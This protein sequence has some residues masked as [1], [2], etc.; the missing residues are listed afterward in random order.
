[1]VD[2]QQL[3][4][5]QPSLWSKSS[6]DWGK[7]GHELGVAAG[8]LNDQTHRPIVSGGWSG[9]AASTA[10][11]RIKTAINCLEAAQAEVSAVGSVLEGLAEAVDIAKRSLQE[12]QGEAQQKEVQ[13]AA[14]GSVRD[15]P[16]PPLLPGAPPNEPLGVAPSAAAHEVAQM[17]K[18]ALERATAA[19]KTAAAE[20]AKLATRT[21]VADPKTAYDTD[22][23]D[24]SRTELVVIAAS[25]PTGPPDLVARWWAGLTPAEQEKLKLAAPATIGGLAG[26]PDAVKG[27]LRGGDGLDRVKLIQY[28]LDNWDKKNDKIYPDDCT[29][30]V[31]DALAAGGLSQQGSFPGGRT[32]T[33]HDWYKTPVGGPRSYSWTSAPGLH[34][35]LTHNNSTELPLDQAKPGDVIFFKSPTEGIHHAAVVTAVVNGHVYYTQHSGSAENS[36][37]NLRQSMYDQAGDPQSPIVVRPRQDGKYLATS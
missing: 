32:D 25:I 27:E 23:A 36:D 3:N 19:D 10:L 4:S 16:R 12:A 24:A 6:S 15:I 20:L 14:D 22:V 26:I 37:L 5:A 35:F 8:D 17:I 21:R 28:A 34:D 11:G 33:E 30:F 7:L 18:S 9:P 31:S 13:I 1:M 2:Y 29:N